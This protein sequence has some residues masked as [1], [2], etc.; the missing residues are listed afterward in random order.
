MSLLV[1]IASDEILN[2]AYAWLCHRR[3][4]YP[5]VANVWWLRQRWQQM[6]RLNNTNTVSSL[7]RWPSQNLSSTS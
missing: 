5:P 1:E 4:G 6:K 2:L 3:R 7:L